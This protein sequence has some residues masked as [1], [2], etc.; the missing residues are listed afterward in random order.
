MCERATDRQPTEQEIQERQD[1]GAQSK[2]EA[3]LHVGGE[4]SAER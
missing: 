1:R 2:V 4:P 3:V